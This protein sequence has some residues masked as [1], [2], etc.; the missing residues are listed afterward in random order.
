MASRPPTRT[1]TVAIQSFDRTAALHNRTVEIDNALVRYVLPATSVTGLLNGTFDVA[2]MPL[3]HY[4][5]LR[6]IGAPF[7]AVP[8]YPDRL[9]LQQYVYT[10]PDTGIRSLA[11]VRGRRVLIPM[12]FMTSSFWHRGMLQE[13][14]GIRPDE[15]Q[16]HTTSPERDP[17]MRLPEGVS[18]TLSRGPHLGLERLLDG[19][20]DCLMTEGT[21]FVP[22][23]QRANVVRVHADAPALQREY[24]QRT[25]FHPIVHIIAVRQEVVDERPGVL[26]ELCA[27]FDQAKQSGYYLLQNERITGL[28][29]IRGYLD[30][31]LDV[32][33]A[34]PWPYGVAGRNGAELDQ[35][36]AYA[37]E[38]GLTERRLTVDDLF[39]PPVRD[40]PFRAT[41]VPDTPPGVLSTLLGY[42]P[43]T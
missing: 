17:R 5:F 26:E 12:Y 22:P 2:E 43:K 28:P 4:A 41:M 10:R 21:P 9:F 27:A 31:T 15:V 38:Q 13:E 8:V 1:I 29:L 19:T 14:Y 18:V 33:G 35:F 6:S 20:T 11:D 36:L 32:F 34:D 40:F 3:A 24:F 23:A 25:G 7:T 39:D 37:H 42:L 16:W 30:E